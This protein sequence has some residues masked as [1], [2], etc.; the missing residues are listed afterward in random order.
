MGCFPPNGNWKDD[1]KP[2][3]PGKEREPIEHCILLLIVCFY[4]KKCGGK[5]LHNYGKSLFLMG[6]LTIN[7]HFP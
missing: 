6:K 1:A 4:Y 2:N 3:E 5:R 7:D